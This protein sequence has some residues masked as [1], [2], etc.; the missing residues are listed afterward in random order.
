MLK[1]NEYV[2]YEL[3]LNNKTTKKKNKKGRKT[4]KQNT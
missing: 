4:K 2:K 1:P 3:K